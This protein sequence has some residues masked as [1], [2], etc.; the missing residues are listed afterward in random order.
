MTAGARMAIKRKG[1]DAPAIVACT[2]LPYEKDF[3]LGA[4][5][6][7]SRRPVE[8]SHAHCAA[9]CVFGSAEFF[10]NLLVPKQTGYAR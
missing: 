1:A 4:T 7:E 6:A 10:A 3:E 8:L 2:L 9:F 5:L